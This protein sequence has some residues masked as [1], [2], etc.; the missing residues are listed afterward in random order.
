MRILLKL[1]MRRSVLHLPAHGNIQL[2]AD[3]LSIAVRS[4]LNI[5]RLG[6]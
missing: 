1:P 6:G 4:M 3:Q 2:N 5:S